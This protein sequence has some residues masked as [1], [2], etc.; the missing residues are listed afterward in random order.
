MTEKKKKKLE[1]RKF[2]VWVT[3]TVFMAG[4]LSFSFVAKNSELALAALPWWG[5]ISMIY[6]G[7]NAA[8]KFVPTTPEE[9]K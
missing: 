3:A 5:G 4:A 2:I 1:S 8:Q 7:A 9:P 6:I